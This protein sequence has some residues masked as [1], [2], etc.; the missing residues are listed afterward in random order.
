[1]RDAKFYI[2]SDPTT[3]EDVTR[4]LHTSDVVGV[5][6]G[7]LQ[8]NCADGKMRFLISIDREH[9]REINDAVPSNP[10]WNKPR[11]FVSYDGDPPKRYVRMPSSNYDSKF[12]D[13]VDDRDKVLIRRVRRISE[14]INL[15]QKD[16]FTG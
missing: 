9:I 15:P 8:R 5:E 6:V 7:P 11:F 1:M 14:K 3:D 16:T 10:H 12:L 13:A 2:E 4:L